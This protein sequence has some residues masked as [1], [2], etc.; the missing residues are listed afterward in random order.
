VLCEIDNVGLKMMEVTKTCIAYVTDEG[1]FF[2][3]I[4]SAIQARRW[5][6]P[7]TD[8]IFINSSSGC[9]VDVISAI[10]LEAGIIFIDASD[11]LSEKLS[12]LNGNEFLG[13]ISTA[14]MGRLLLGE[15]VHD[16]YDQIIY[17]DGDT[18]INSSLKDIEDFNV[19]PGKF[20]ASPDFLAVHAYLNGSTLSRYFNAGVMK[21]NRHGWIGPIAFQYYLENGGA[22]HDQGAL[23]T[24]GANSLILMS[25]RWNFPKQFLHLL[26]E[27]R[28][29]ITHFMAHPKPWDGVY[30]P[31]GT[32][33]HQVYSDAIKVYPALKKIRVRIG[34]MRR[35]VYRW[36]SVRNNI[37][38]RFD[39]TIRS[40][41]RLL[42]GE[43]FEAN[44]L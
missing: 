1:F 8:V 3:T 13:R 32:A 27:N 24:C 28:P 29:I 22:N 19:P 36:R 26:G 10:C 9:S 2:P 44:G 31:W 30:F 11:Y 25:S 14:S 23:N 35:F 33:E 21:F 7:T 37:H 41:D 6:Q 34:L 16:S 18:Q 15:I 39:P 5:C 17:L 20:L 40:V 43:K 42:D 4:V 38:N 12:H